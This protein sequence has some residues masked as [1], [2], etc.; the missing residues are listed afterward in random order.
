MVR[1]LSGIIFPDI[2]VS[3]ELHND[4]IPVGGFGAVRDGRNPRDSLAF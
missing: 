2:Y 4:R 1:P 3:P